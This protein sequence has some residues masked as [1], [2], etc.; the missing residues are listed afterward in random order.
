MERI[1][2]VLRPPL[3][4]K[5]CRETQKQRRRCQ[6]ALRR[7]LTTLATIGRV[8]APDLNCVDPQ[9]VQSDSLG[10]FTSIGEG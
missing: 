10:S 5:L 2:G 6:V 9:G 8:Y 7:F 1:E 3:V 4:L